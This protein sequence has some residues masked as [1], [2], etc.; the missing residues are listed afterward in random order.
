MQKSGESESRKPQTGEQ[1]SSETNSAATSKE[2]VSDLR[3]QE[4]GTNTTSDR[5]SGPSPDGALDESGE[6]KDAGPM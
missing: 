5:D 1:E 2:T 6:T 3:E 4:K